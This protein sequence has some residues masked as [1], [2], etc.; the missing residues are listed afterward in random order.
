MLKKAVSAN[1]QKASNGERLEVTVIPEDSLPYS[2]Q[3]QIP[4]NLIGKSLDTLSKL[5]PLFLVFRKLAASDQL[6]ERAAIIELIPITQGHLP[7][8]REALEAY[9]WLETAYIQN[10]QDED[11]AENR[12]TWCFAEC[13][14]W[15]S[16][17]VPKNGRSQ[18]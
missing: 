13:R 10:L 9:F 1:Q 6:R 16:H 4:S 5:Y 17:F 8:V 2:K 11:H 15:S 18:L 12:R 14:P 7:V 3:I